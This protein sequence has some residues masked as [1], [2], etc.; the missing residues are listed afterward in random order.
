MSSP[1][2]IPELIQT[3]FR[4]SREDIRPRRD[5]CHFARVCRAW[6]D[7]AIPLIWE[8]LF[9]LA[10][11][12]QRLPRTAR[13][14]HVTGAYLGR[15]GNIG[16]AFPTFDIARP[17]TKEDWAPVLE[18]SRFIKHFG[19]TELLSEPRNYSPAT[20]DAILQCPYPLFPNLR[21]LNINIR[22][23]TEQHTELVQSF[24]SPTVTALVVQ[25]H[26][27]KILGNCNLLARRCP[28]LRRI[29]L[30]VTNSGVT[31]V[32]SIEIADAVAAWSSLHSVD[33]KIDACHPNLL[34][35]LARSNSL[36][37]L[38]LWFTDGAG[39]PLSLSEPVTSSF[40]ALQTLK[41]RNVSVSRVCGILAALDGSPI[42][43]I[44][45]APV[46]LHQSQD[47]LRR[48]L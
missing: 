30:D 28:S 37:Y 19:F 3:I 31:S 45:L 4:A 38:S 39:G 25:S 1:I 48:V 43:T 5:L 11:L 23:P 29:Q 15:H 20:I 33:L 13:T 24:L 41:L 35:S 26:S 40:T 10:H 17:L 12:L 36:V 21:W 9:D 6:H 34:P 47:N 27:A 44:C 32:P 2:Q 42:E 14:V 22:N 18:R 8:E 7:V 46:L 16:I